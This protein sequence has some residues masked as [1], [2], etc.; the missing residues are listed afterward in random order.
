MVLR[1]PSIE[2]GSRLTTVMSPIHGAHGLADL[3]VADSTQVAERLGQHQVGLQ[4]GEQLRVEPV[5]G[6]AAMHR[7][8]DLVVH[9]PAAAVGGN[10]A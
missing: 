9:R 2:W 3:T 1:M 7:G 10:A 5:K 6:V 8:A 4:L